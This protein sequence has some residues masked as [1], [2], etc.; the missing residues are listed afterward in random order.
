VRTAPVAEVGDAEQ[1][2]GL[3]DA[4]AHGRGENGELFEAVGEFFFD[5]VGDELVQWVL[6]DVTDEVGE[7]AGR[8]GAGVAAIDGDPAGEGAAGEVRDEAVDRAE[9]VVVSRLAPLVGS[10][11]LAEVRSPPRL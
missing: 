1:V 6:A 10:T 3:F 11:V 9:E 5:G 2:E 8:V 4:F 7:L